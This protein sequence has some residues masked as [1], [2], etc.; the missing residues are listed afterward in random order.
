MPDAPTKGSAF[1]NSEPKSITPQ[2]LP[3]LKE[4]E[5]VSGRERE[6]PEVTQPAGWTG[7]GEAQAGGRR[8]HLA[9]PRVISAPDPGRV[10]HTPNPTPGLPQS[11]RG[12]LRYLPRNWTLRASSPAAGCRRLCPRARPAIQVQPGSC[13]HWAARASSWGGRRAG[14]GATPGRAGQYLP[15]R[16][17]PR[18]GPAPARV[19]SGL[20]SRPSLHPSPPLSCLILSPWA[21]LL[22]LHLRRNLPRNN[23]FTCRP[24]PQHGYFSI[25]VL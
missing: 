2:Q 1:Q 3:H 20:L 18:P 25:P 6:L 11:R 17:A 5:P 12:A 4:A 10:V 16:P 23:F 7:S 24:R 14:A 13:P 21:A 8:E 22:G 15:A 19:G 9:A